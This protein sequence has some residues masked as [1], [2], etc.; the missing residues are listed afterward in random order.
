MGFWADLKA[1]RAAKQAQALFDSQLNDWNQE[2]QVLT[3]ALDIFTGAAN[4]EEPSDNNLVQKKGELILWTGTAIFHEAGRTPTRYTG[5]SQGIS[6]PIVAGIRYRVGSMA[7][8]V[9]PGEEMQMDKEQ[10]MVK[11][12]NQRL[13]FVGP[14]NSTEWAFAKFLAAT[15]NPTRDDFLFAVS[16]R[17]KTS[18]LRFTPTDGIAFSRLLALALYAY[19]KGLPATVKAIKAEIKEIENDKPKLILPPSAVKQTKG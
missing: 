15:S 7:G 13:I 16:N 9:I 6:I 5:R 14:N 4:G 11:L 8:Q 10:G 2:H 1:K 19:E 3:H 17:K 12:T 18:G